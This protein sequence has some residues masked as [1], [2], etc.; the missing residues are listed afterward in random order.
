MKRPARASG[1]L[2]P[3]I[4]A[5]APDAVEQDAV[6]LWASAQVTA[7]DVE[8][9]PEYGSP[10]WRA[11][12]ATDPRRA[13]ALITAA[14]QWRRRTAREAWLDELLDKDPERWFSIV[15][16]QADDYARSIAGGLARRPTHDELAA[17][18]TVRAQAREVVA[19]PGWP[20]VAIPGRPGWWRHYGPHGR[21]L[22]L[23]H[24]H[25]QEKAA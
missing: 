6:A 24:N 3:R 12:R 17:R 16:A 13:A 21:Q 20:P 2:S 14:E 18:R 7:L 11:L 15:T 5:A 9:F 22:D 10:A 1:A 23:P 19:T 8:D 4:A 25:R